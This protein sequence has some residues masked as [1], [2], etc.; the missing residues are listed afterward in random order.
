MP[1]SIFYLSRDSKNQFDFKLCS[2][3]EL[4]PKKFDFSGTLFGKFM[5]TSN[6]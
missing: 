6:R 2:K 1:T 4:P 5:S 3:N